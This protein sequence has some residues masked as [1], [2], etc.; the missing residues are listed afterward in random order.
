MWRLLKNTGTRY[1]HTTPISLKTAQYRHELSDLRK[2]VVKLGSAV[3]TR[4]DECGLALGRLASIV[5][6]VRILCS[7][8]C[9]VKCLKNNMYKCFLF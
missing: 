1:L 4:E 5:E 8:H 7:S 9:H 6:Q 2:I 3:I